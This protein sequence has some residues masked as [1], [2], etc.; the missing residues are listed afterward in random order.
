MSDADCS[1]YRP[2]L[3]GAPAHLQRATSRVDVG[4]RAWMEGAPVEAVV[5]SRSRRLL[6]A[7]LLVVACGVPVFLLA[8]AVRQEFGP[9]LAVDEA[10]IA[11]A[12]TFTRQWGLAPA[13]ILLQAISHPLVAYALATLVVI[14]VWVTKGMRAR[15]IWAFLTMMAGWILSEVIKLIVQRV[16]PILDSPL[17]QPGGYSFPSGHALNITVATTVLLLLLWPLLS[18]AGRRWG[19]VAGVVVVLAV[20]ADRVF[21]GVHFP[22]DVFAGFVLGCCI[23]FSSWIGF[24]GRTGEDSSSASPSRP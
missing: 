20:G 15:A 10:A 5:R 3:V 2:S 4:Y 1:G 19:I 11:A 18:A 7:L 17:S 16:R 6:R 22:S 13:L 8:L 14:W 9:L 12:T 23:T 21:L 24:V